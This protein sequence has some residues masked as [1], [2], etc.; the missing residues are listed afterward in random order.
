MLPEVRRPS[1]QHRTCLGV[2]SAA[3][4]ASTHPYL[5]LSLP[6]DAPFELKPSPGKGWGVFATK[7]I[8]KG[9]RVLTE[10]T[11]FVIRKPAEHTTEADI[12]QA[13]ATLTP[14]E[15]AQFLSIVYTHEAPILGIFGLN[16]W[17][18]PKIAV[19]GFFVLHSRINHSCLPNCKALTRA[20]EGLSATATRDILKGEEITTC[21]GTD[22][23]R[24]VRSDR[25]RLLQFV[26]KCELC[27]AGTTAQQLSDLRRTLLRG[28]GYVLRSRPGME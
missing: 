5:S 9:S 19:Y 23:D 1:D 17:Y 28:L 16:C 13:L 24:R 20:E 10:H 6:E 22:F 4:M 21:Y 11:L 18:V 14:A 3:K 27:C 25:H 7:D 26:C 12:W 8:I 2:R 15:A